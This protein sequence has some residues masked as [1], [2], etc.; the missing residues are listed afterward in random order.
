MRGSAGSPFRLR[1]AISSETVF[2]RL[3]NCHGEDPLPPGLVE[4]EEGVEVEVG[5]PL[6]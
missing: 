3:F 4:V 5:A 6:L 2:R 1:A